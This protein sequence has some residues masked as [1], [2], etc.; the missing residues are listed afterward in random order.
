MHHHF[1]R[2]YERARQHFLGLC[3]ET[4]AALDHIKHPELGPDGELF[5]DIALW[6]DTDCDHLLIITSATHGI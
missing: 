6:G 4:N 2:S 1:S 3:R 5:T